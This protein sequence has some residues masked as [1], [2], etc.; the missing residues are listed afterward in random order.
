MIVFVSRE[1]HVVVILFE[2][3]R[4]AVV[5]FRWVETENS[6]GTGFGC[7]YGFGLLIG[8]ICNFHLHLVDWFARIAVDDHIFAVVDAKQCKAR[9]GKQGETFDSG[10]VAFG[11]NDVEAS[12]QALFYIIGAMG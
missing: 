11:K 7:E 9:D 8:A 6:V 2:G 10:A 1:A 4:G 3:N 5:A 12:R